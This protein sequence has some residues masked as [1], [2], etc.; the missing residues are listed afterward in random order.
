MTLNEYNFLHKWHFPNSLLDLSCPLS[1]PIRWWCLS[2]CNL[3]RLKWWMHAWSSTC[4][5]CK[6]I[7]MRKTC[8]WW[9]IVQGMMIVWAH[10]L[11]PLTIHRWETGFPWLLLDSFDILQVYSIIELLIFIL[12]TIR[13]L[14]RSYR[15]FTFVIL[16]NMLLLLK[17]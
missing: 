13:I 8:C 14:R 10:L 1:C 6:A 11:I 4:L 16:M 3:L 12:L 15:F 5:L 9:G 2:I 17:K 7:H